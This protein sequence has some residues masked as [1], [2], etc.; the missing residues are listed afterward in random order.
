MTLRGEKPQPKGYPVNPQT[1]GEHLKKK[2]MEL[3]LLQ[4]EVARRI[5]I[6]LTTYRNWEWNRTSPR[7]R[8]MPAVILFLGYAP[9][10]LPA[11]WGEWLRMV[12]R[13]VG[14]TQ[15]Q[16]AARVGVDPSTVRGWETERHRATSESVGK[17]EALG[18]GFKRRELLQVVVYDS[19]EKGLQ[20]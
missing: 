10:V 20:R 11:S 4:R 8:Y 19:A 14:L 1:I 5:G 7:V 3:N 13:S 9:Y 6:D 18:E 2:R 16:F 12:R 15:K 17:V